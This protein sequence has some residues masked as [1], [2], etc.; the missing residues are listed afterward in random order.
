MKQLCRTLLMLG[1]IVGLPISF[2]LANDFTYND[3]GQRDP[4]WP[5][6][7]SGG[8]IVNYD[9]NFSASELVLEGIIAD[10]KSRLAIINGNIVEEGKKIGFYT[11]QQIQADRVVLVKDGQ[12]LVLRMKKEE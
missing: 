8:A 10:G 12:S 6:V 9:S 11:V 1:F 2:G 3:H 7:S 5:L 4:F